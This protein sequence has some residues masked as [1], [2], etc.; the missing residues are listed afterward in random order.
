M[1]LSAEAIA[2]WIKMGLEILWPNGVLYESKLPLMPEESNEL[3]E[4]TKA[5]LTSAFPDQVHANLGSNIADDGVDIL[6][7]MLQN[8]MVVKSLFYMLLDLLWL[9]IFPE[10]HDILACGSALETD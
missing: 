3:V 5:L 6:H 4:K 10:L 7:E 8:R 1:H 2:G 9:E